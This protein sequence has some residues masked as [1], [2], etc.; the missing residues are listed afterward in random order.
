MRRKGQ[1][2]TKIK[3][4]PTSKQLVLSLILSLMIAPS[5]SALVDPTSDTEQ[6]GG[7]KSKKPGLKLRM[8]QAVS[9]MVKRDLL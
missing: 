1:T 9:D 6:F 4:K 2:S 3:M 7:M 8:T 5:L